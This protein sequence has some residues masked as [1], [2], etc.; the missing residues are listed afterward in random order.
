MSN[1]SDV[2]GKPERKAYYDEMFENIS[3]AW[4]SAY[5]NEEGI[6]NGDTQCCYLLALKMNLLKPEQIETA[7]AHLIRTIERKNYHLSTGFVGVSY[8]LP[9][10]CGN[11]LL[12]EL[13]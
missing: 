4:R 6:V 3:A 7:V 12:T 8:L 2:L 10:L 9:I 5:M 11:I 13:Q 1:V